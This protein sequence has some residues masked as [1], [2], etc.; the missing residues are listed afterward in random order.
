ME[1]ERAKQ[2]IDLSYLVNIDIRGI[3]VYL[4]QL[5][6]DNKTAT[7]FPLDN[8]DHVQSVDINL[9]NETGPIN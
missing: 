1:L 7:I 8:M 9:L 6:L 5:N 2:I 3:P 4:Q